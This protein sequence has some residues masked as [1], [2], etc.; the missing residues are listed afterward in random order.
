MKIIYSL[1][2][3]LAFISSINAQEIPNGDFEE[4][5]I[6]QGVNAE[7]PTGWVTSSFAGVAA[8]LAPNAEKTTDSEQGTYALKLT[9]INGF[10]P[11]EPL[12]GGAFFDGPLG[13]TPTELRGYYKSSIIGND[14]ASIGVSIVSGGDLIGTV[15]IE[16]EANQSSYTYFSAQIDYLVPNPTAEWFYLEIYSSVEFGNIG[17]TLFI[18]GLSFD[19]STAT[20]NFN[21]KELGLVIGPNPVSEVLKISVDNFSDNMDLTIYDVHGRAIEARQFRQSLSINTSFYP[22]GQYFVVLTDPLKGL[23]QTSRFTV[24]N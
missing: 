18:D 8:G 24:K 11:D 19:G 6:L 21:T 9:T 15:T 22:N 5:E 3:F 7:F 20:N 23:V 16:F 1:V 2:L 13:S 10:D 17:S 4:W 14:T 12:V